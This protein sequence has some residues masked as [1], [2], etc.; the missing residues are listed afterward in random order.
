MGRGSPEPQELWLSEERSGPKDLEI[1]KLAR[2]SQSEKQ[3]HSNR[4]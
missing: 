2:I 1:L 3:A 4:Y